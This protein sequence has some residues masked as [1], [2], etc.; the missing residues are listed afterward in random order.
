MKYRFLSHTADVKF[1][2]Y[3]KTLNESFENSA[4]AMF[5]VMYTGK[6]KSSKQ[7]SLQSPTGLQ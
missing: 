3:G 5:N 1:K 2:A 6:I 4:L 7:T